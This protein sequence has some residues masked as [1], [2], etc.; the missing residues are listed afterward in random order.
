MNRVFVLLFMFGLSVAAGAQELNCQVV[1]NSE[2]TGQANASVFKTLQNTI[3]EFI[4]QTRWTNREFLPQERINCSMFIN[5]NSY[6]GNS[7]SGSIQV[8]SSRPVFGSTMVSPV[9]NFNDDDLAFEYTEYEPL[10]FSPSQ[11]DSNLVS[12]IGYYV[13]TILGLDADTFTEQ[14]GTPYFE[15]A[16]QIVGTAQQSS[17]SGWKGT[18]GNRSRYQLNANLLSNTY[19]G[20]RNALYDYHRN[21]LDVMHMSPEEGK[22]AIATALIDLERMNSR[23]PNSLLLRTF[24]DAKADEVEQIFSGGPQVNIR[25]VVDALNNMAPTFSEKWGNIRF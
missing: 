22:E 17:Y 3:S 21:G 6:D 24:F 8:Q 13:Y 18:D 7:F 23:R 19:S 2:K 16:N 5:I 14:G 15:T 1:V 11:F 9:F 12:I 20:Y 25:E 10:E 4:N